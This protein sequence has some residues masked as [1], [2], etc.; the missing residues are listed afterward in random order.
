MDEDGKFSCCGGFPGSN[1]FSISFEG[2][3]NFIV[4]LLQKAVNYK[5]DAR[6]QSQFVNFFTLGGSISE[7]PVIMN[8]FVSVVGRDVHFIGDPC[9]PLMVWYENIRFFDLLRYFE[10]RDLRYFTQKWLNAKGDKPAQV[11][12]AA[13]KFLEGLESIPFNGGK[14]SFD[15]TLHAQATAS[16]LALCVFQYLYLDSDKFL[17]GTTDMEIFEK[18]KLSLKSPYYSYSNFEET[19]GTF[20]LYESRYSLAACYKD[21]PVPF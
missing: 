1:Q 21:F 5:K 7:L 8:A 20:R 11:Y 6:S 3:T 12:L 15:F 9:K 4:W 13:Q 2:A 16:S 10:G 18:E 14:Q 17:K 19:E